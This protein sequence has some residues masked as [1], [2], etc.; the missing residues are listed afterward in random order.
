[1]LTASATGDD[2]VIGEAAGYVVKDAS[3]SG[4]VEAARG[5]AMGQRQD[6]A[7]RLYPAGLARNGDVRMCPLR[8]YSFEISLTLSP[9]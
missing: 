5:V 3:L 6:S 8:L 1:M 4:L 9:Q 2:A 7:Y